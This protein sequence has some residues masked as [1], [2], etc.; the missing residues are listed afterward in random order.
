MLFV[1]VL[2]VKGVFLLEF[3]F[4]FELF[5]K[6]LEGLFFLLELFVFC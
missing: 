1:L 4:F 5:L 6:L 2:F 3:V